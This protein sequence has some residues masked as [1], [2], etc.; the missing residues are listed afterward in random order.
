MILWKRLCCLSSCLALS[1]CVSSRNM[2]CLFLSV[3]SSTIDSSLF[4][5]L[6]EYI[7]FAFVH[8]SFLTF[9]S[10]YGSLNH[11]LLFSLCGC[12]YC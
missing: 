12:A 1:Y 3:H 8:F 11:T 5:S 10:F 7:S 2:V 6:C 9:L 4:G